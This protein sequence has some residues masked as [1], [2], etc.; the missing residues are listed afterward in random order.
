MC[1]GAF[2]GASIDVALVSRRSVARRDLLE[3]AGKMRL[4]AVEAGLCEPRVKMP[5]RRP[6][7]RCSFVHLVHVAGSAKGYS[8]CSETREGE[9]IDLPL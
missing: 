7:A 3:F 4:S 8:P 2:A 1:C 9:S 5:N 6:A